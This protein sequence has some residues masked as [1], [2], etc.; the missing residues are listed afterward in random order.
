MP[1]KKQLFQDLIKLLEAVKKPAD[2][3]N[4]HVDELI[5]AAIAGAVRMIQIREKSSLADALKKTREG[6]NQH[7]DVILQDIQSEH[8]E[9]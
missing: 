9:S 2:V 4:V 6:I 8:T 5:N 1:E 3:T 7:F